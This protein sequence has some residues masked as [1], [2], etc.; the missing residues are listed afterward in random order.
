M[1]REYKPDDYPYF[2]TWGFVFEFDV[3][4]DVC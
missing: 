4:W 2:N 3:I 1:Q